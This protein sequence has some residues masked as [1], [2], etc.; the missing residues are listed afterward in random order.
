MYTVILDEGIVIRDADQVVVAP[1]QN[2]DD[3]DFLA[4]I[5]WVMVEGN[6]P[7]TIQSRTVQA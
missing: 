7:L 1:R 6:E 2:A 4:Y 3:P 5:N